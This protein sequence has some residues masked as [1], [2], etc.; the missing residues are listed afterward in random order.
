LNLSDAFTDIEDLKPAKNKKLPLELSV[1]VYNIN[2]G[3]NT[4]MLKKCES[5]FGYS[6]FINKIREYQTQGLTL[7]EVITPVIEYCIKNNILKNYLTEH[8]SEVINMIFG[9][10]DREMDIAV[11][12]R[13]ARE[14]GLEEGIEKGRI[15]ERQHFL[16]LLDQGLTT[17]EIKQR[18]NQF[19]G[20]QS[21]TA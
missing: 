16:E 15:E 20:T 6:F 21:C 5:L 4:E 13:E 8:G 7:E 18:L 1:Q 2:D 12:R 17:A 14:E 19:E 3:H 11:N 10:Y 9:E